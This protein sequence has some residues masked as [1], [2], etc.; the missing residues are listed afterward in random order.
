[1]GIIKS[2][3]NM[4][5]TDETKGQI[6]FK[7]EKIQKK[8]YSSK[9]KNLREKIDIDRGSKKET[10]EPPKGPFAL[11]KFPRGLQLP[12]STEQSFSKNEDRSLTQSS[13]DIDA[14]MSE[15]SEYSN[16]K[17]IL[18]KN[19]SINLETF[20]QNSCSTT[21]LSTSRRE[22]GA[23]LKFQ[24]MI[25]PEFFNDKPHNNIQNNN[26]RKIVEIENKELYLIDYSTCFPQ[27][28]YSN[29]TCNDF[30]EDVYLNFD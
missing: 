2:N 23:S 28:Y 15:I 29:S 1:M 26:I 9:E 4:K 14:N 18:D 8:L 3:R 17:E 21:E 12:T 24:T 7:I 30:N 10:S 20:D 6:V 11:I 16:C 5:G 19:I 22:S 13:C 25:V 27:I